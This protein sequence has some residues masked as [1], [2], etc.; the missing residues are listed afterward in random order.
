MVS[1]TAAM[2][3]LFEAV[4]RR[5]WCDYFGEEDIGWNPGRCCAGTILRRLEIAQLEKRQP[6]TRDFEVAFVR[7]RI[8]FSLLSKLG[9]RLLLP[10]LGGTRPI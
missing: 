1:A 3:K 8:K 4:H 9:V 6:Q 7:E 10:T 2:M 5:P